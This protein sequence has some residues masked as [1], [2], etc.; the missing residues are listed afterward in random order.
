[1]T[2]FHTIAL[3]CVL[4]ALAALPA[5]AADQLF[6]AEEEGMLQSSDK[7]EGAK[8]Y[9]SSDWNA[10]N[11]RKVLIGSVTVYFSD[12]SKSKEIDPDTLKAL[13][14]E[15]KSIVATSAGRY[16][17]VV[18][19]PGPGV[20]LV[21]VAIVDLQMKNKKRGLLGYTPVGFVVTSAANAAGARLTLAG[22]KIQS[23]SV[24]SE[25]GKLLGLTQVDEIQQLD[26]EKE[27]TWDDIKMTLRSFADRIIDVRFG[28]AP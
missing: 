23:E 11:Y 28:A 20:A 24:D 10:E 8:V 26:A 19:Q 13:A 1:M 7:V 21:N 2:R 14:D 22:A 5:F 3:S 18:T 15:M 17:E 6:T 16:A 27:M 4:G 25:T 9:T 12:D